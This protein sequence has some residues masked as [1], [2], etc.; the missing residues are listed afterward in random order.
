VD[1]TGIADLIAALTGVV[2][3]IVTLYLLF[4]L[5]RVEQT[6]EHIKELTNSN[7]SKMQKL[8]EKAV[9]H[10]RKSS[11]RDQERLDQEGGED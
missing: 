8:L 6:T 4:R 2:S 11:V 1:L 9:E 5:A 10:A 7:F 3:L